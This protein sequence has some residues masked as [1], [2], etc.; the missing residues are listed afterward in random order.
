[1]A[2]STTLGVLV[3]S[4]VRHAAS[5]L[6]IFA[7]HPNTEVRAVCEEAVA[8][9]WARRDSRQVAE[10]YGI[11]FLADPAAALARADVDLVLVCSEPTRHAR[12][13]AQALDAGKHTLID[14][15]MATT[16]EEATQLLDAAAAARGKCTVIHRLYGASIQRTRHWIDAG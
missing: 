11:P 9:E 2:E 3:L 5:Y 10:Q 12:L 1:M 4:G 7:A 16:L 6:P 8:P 15:P 13:A 14:K